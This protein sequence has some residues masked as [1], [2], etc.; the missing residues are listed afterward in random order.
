[1]VAAAAAARVS[2]AV[3]VFMDCLHRW[4]SWTVFI[5]DREE[6]PVK[7]SKMDKVISASILLR[8][9]TVKWTRPKWTWKWPDCWSFI[10]LG[11]S[12]FFGYGWMNS[13][14]AGLALR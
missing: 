13:P 4:C 1:M 11:L 10:F 6:N 2:S 7:N 3:L 9:W 8:I 5:G 14:S 12:H